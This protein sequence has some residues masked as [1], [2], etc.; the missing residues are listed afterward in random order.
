MR[1]T[2]LRI[3][4]SGLAITAIGI[5]LGYRVGALQTSLVEEG[6]LV[7][8]AIL[9]V[10][11]LVPGLRARTQPQAPAEHVAG[12]ERSW[13]QFRREL[14]R[15]RRFGRSFVIGRIPAGDAKAKA[16]IRT[17]HAR[18]AMLPLLVR[19]VDQIWYSRGTV[20]VLLPETDRAGMQSLLQRLQAAAP[21]LLPQDGIAVAQFP[22]D[23]LTT[24]SL[25]AKMR[26]EPL[27]LA[28]DELTLARDLEAS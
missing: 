2:N 19:S 18:L 13:D 17:P 14:D 21:G 20:Y 12:P 3:A 5:L 26:P 1:R 8:V 6:L 11:A 28:A 4:L 25:L 10:A 22:D 23:G 15:S 27:V 9:I 24:G 7:V 16:S